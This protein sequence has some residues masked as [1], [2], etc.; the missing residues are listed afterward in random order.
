MSEQTLGMHERLKGI[1]FSVIDPEFDDTLIDDDTSLF[2]LGVDSMNVVEL[3]IAIE[4]EFL[5]TIT[6]DEVDEQLFLR[7]GNL[8]DLLTKKLSLQ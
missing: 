3:L 5:I 2:D 7:F 8:H 1:L 4:T 6:E